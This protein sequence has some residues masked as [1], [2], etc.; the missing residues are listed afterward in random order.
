MC[1]AVIAIQAHR[2]WPLIVLANRDEFHARPATPIGPWQEARAVLGGI[3]LQAG[4]T[5]LATDIR[6]RLALL[7]NV[8][9]P[10][11]QKANAPTRG[12]L[13]R[14]YLLENI[15]SQSYLQR[16]APNASQFN[17]FNLVLADGPHA[18]WHASNYQAP[19]AQP[20]KPGVHGL[21]NASLNTAWPKTDRVVQRVRAHLE[22]GGTPDTA[23]LMS[24]MRDFEGAP[25]QSLPVTGLTIER[26]RLLASPFI[27]SPDYG[28]RCT[29]LLMRHRSGA[30]WVQED[31]FDA[32][33]ERVARVVWQ[34]EAH[35]VGR[36]HSAWSQVEDGV[37]SR[38]TAWSAST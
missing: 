4:G 10:A 16:L 33:G 26:E 29:T 9:D 37:G 34:H 23:Y 38:I 5:W 12:D 25:D 8:R 13:P 7:T 18:V 11:K 32:R 1:L 24:I 27:V 3:D 2:D 14:S 30:A 17:G 28:T 20:I 15:S 35:V 19:F 21:S 31:R 6:G 22:Q 36:A